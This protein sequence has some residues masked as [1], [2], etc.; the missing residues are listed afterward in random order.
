MKSSIKFPYGRSH[1]GSLIKRGYHYVDKTR[2]IEWLEEAE[3]SYIIF[4]RPRRFGKSLF[5][6]TLEHYYGVEHK[7][8]FDTFFGKYYIGQHP[9]EERNSYWVLKFNFS[10]I[11][12]H[13]PTSTAEGFLKNIRSGINHF[14]R[15]YLQ[16]T[17]EEEKTI[18]SQ[19]KA[20]LMLS[21][22]MDT[23]QDKERLPI[24]LL[25]D[26]Y[27]HFT[28]ELM[29]FDLES[30]RDFVSRNGFIRKFYEMIKIGTGEGIIEQIFITGVS[31]ITLDSLTSGF[32]IASH[33]SLEL[34]LNGLMGFE[35][36]E[37]QEM[38]AY[39]APKEKI[40]AIVKDMR[41]WYNGYHFNQE[42]TENMYNAD[43]VLYFL[44]AYKRYGKYPNKMLDTNIT[45]D[46]SKLRR[47]FS[48]KTPVKNYEVLQEILEGKKQ[49][50]DIVQEFSFERAF[51]RNDFISLLY[52][53]GFLTI[54]RGKR[55]L[56]SLKVPNHV[57]KKLYF[58][59]FITRLLQRAELPAQLQL[60]QNSLQEMA[61]EGNP[62]P[63]FQV[64]EQVLQQ[65]SRRDYQ[66]FEEK[67]VKSIIMALAVQTDTF[68]INSERESTGGYTDILFLEKPPFE[69]DHQ[70]V[71]ELKYLK[72]KNRSQLAATQ[73]K[74]K[75]QL[76][77]YL[78]GD[79]ELQGLKNLQAWTVVVVKDEVVV[80]RVQ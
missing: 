16:L 66:N 20:N 14:I 43:M 23:I 49:T 56:L 21:F 53:L 40:P 52:Y 9:T 74:A 30:F 13:T 61:Y 70:Y 33:F 5:I 75:R 65:L 28:N 67:H 80:E 60:L 77:D 73:K 47:L 79:V 6:S 1:F 58:D 37:V 55:R 10:G 29:A 25:I 50:A 7:N 78:K 44:K 42:A 18:L 19:K 12:T 4:L 31:P 2:Y 34:A 59:F 3:E 17:K 63:F 11:D 45:S 22:L 38:L 36:K 54:E 41:K 62:Q 39:I 68:F 15:Q 8:D 46:Y 64:I 69:L 51:T 27:D 35:E 26:E 72:K 32:N 57:I 48:L 71:M 76:L 24:Y